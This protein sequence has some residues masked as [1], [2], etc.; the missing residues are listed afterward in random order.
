MSY[1]IAAYAL[2]A[3]VLLGYVLRVRMARMAILK[4]FKPRS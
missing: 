4:A 3:I 2:T 1:L